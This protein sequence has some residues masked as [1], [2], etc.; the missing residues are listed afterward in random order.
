MGQVITLNK[1]VLDDLRAGFLGSIDEGDSFYD[2]ASGGGWD[3]SDYYSSPGDSV[4]VG[5]MDYAS[6]GY[7]EDYAAALDAGYS[8]EEA[9]QIADIYA[10]SYQNPD[11]QAALEAGYSSDEALQISQ[12]YAES[13]Y[14]DQQAIQ[15]GSEPLVDPNFNQNYQPSQPGQQAPK[16]AAPGAGGMGP[17]SGGGGGGGSKPS[18]SPA[19][20]PAMTAAQ[21]AAE[22]LKLQKQGVDVTRVVANTSQQTQANIDTMK[23]LIEQAKNPKSNWFSQSTITSAMPNG[24]V[25]ALG[26]LAIVAVL[27]MTQANPK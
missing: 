16:K 11:Y 14:F 17:G 9:S 22:L 13:D 2:D 4:F 5:P 12:M 8:S 26:V 20:T 10:E 7:A 1:N 27:V 3:S 21:L 15:Q 18:G 19:Q 23:R 25:V 6:D 24:A